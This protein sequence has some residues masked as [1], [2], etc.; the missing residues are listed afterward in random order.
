MYAC[1]RVCVCGWSVCGIVSAR[2][3]AC[4][5]ASVYVCVCVD[6]VC[7]AAVCAKMAVQ[8]FIYVC[9]SVWF[10]KE[11][12]CAY[13]CVSVRYCVYVCVCVWTECERQPSL[14]RWMCRLLNC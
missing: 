10:M 9:E 11:C 14:P 5:Y 1:V 3:S 7:V 12:A 13:V 8:L 4:M 6:G 2:D